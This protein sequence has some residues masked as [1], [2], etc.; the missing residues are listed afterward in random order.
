MRAEPGG[1]CGQV[2]TL[3][4]A[5]RAPRRRPVVHD[6]RVAVVGHLEQVGAHGVE[7]VVAGQSLVDALEQR[8]AVAGPSTIAAATARL[9]VTIGLAVIRSS[10]P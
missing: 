4:H 9:S 5:R 2:V 3:R 10:S 7:A 8:E 1:A 6:R